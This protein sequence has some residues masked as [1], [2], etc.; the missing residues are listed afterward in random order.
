MAYHLKELHLCTY[1]KK[2]QKIALFCRI[3]II[4]LDG[5]PRYWSLYSI[6]R[7]AAAVQ[8]VHVAFCRIAS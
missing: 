2:L 1:L 6:I 8:V 5:R 4:S 7:K 3:D